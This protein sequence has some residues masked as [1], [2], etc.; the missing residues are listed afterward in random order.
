M[1]STS[2]RIEASPEAVWDLVSDV[3]RMGEWSP[4]TVS[5]DWVQGA[6]GPTVG[7]RFKGKNKRRVGWTTTCTVV[8][9]E[10]GRTF[11]FEV[12]GGDTRWRYDIEADG[13]ACLVT[14][15]CEI[16]NEPGAVGRFLTRLGT[17][18]SWADRPADIT[19]GMERT[20]AALKAVAEGSKPS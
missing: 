4:E 12:G 14:E 8:E 3:T 13:A 9:A 7:A 11:A 10:R 15:T 6:R 2:I 20:L 1:P 19:R 17:G 18:V 16:L 5:A